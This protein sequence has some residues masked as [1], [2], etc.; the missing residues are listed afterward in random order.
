MIDRSL[1]EASIIAVFVIVIMLDIATKGKYMTRKAGVVLLIIG[2]LFGFIY[3]SAGMDGQPSLMFDLMTFLTMT[4]LLVWGIRKR[5]E[6]KRPPQT[7]SSA[8]ENPS[9]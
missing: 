9:I 1:L 8:A 5:M 6:K 3:V 2:V 7:S 4:Y